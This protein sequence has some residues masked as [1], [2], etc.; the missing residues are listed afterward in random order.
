MPRFVVLSKLSPQGYRAFRRD[1]AVILD[2]HGEVERLGGTVIDQFALLGPHD[3]CTI[4]D[5]RDNDA[6]FQLAVADRGEA[7]VRTLL[8]AIDLNLFVRL[9]GQN[10][11]TTGP[12]RWQI[13]AAKYFKPLAVIGTEHFDEVRV[14]AIFIANHVS[15][16]DGAAMWAALP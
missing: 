10:T 1:P 5:V 6:A 11:E 9:V 12:H 2:L 7:V 14:P 3:C 8:P 15:F 13:S 4:I 16:M